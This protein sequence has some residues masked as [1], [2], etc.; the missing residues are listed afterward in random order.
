MK[1]I[2]VTVD[3]NESSQLLVDKAAEQAEKFGSKVWILHIAD[4]EPDFIGNEVGPQYIRDIR[5]K[6]LLHEHQVIRKYI[7][8]LKAKS[9]DADGLLIAGATV[10]TIL[11]EVQKLN[12][13]MVII[14]HHKH[15]IMYK[16]F[17]GRTDTAI[18]S[19]SKVPV[20]VVQLPAD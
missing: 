10:K 7:D 3:L 6:E 4:P 9:I 12:I 8:Q 5:V 19:K 1:N 17:R 15:S 18:V 20:M 2:L 16:I 11:Q 13:D 14:G